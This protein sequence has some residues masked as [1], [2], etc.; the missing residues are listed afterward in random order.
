MA[1]D[2]G[3]TLGGKLL[4]GGV[5]RVHAGNIALLASAFALAGEAREELA[6]RVD[7]LTQERPCI[8]WLRNREARW[9]RP[10][11][12]VRVRHLAGPRL[13]RHATVREIAPSSG[14][15]NGEKARPVG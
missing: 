10:E 14:L 1:L 11:L 15:A 13:V 8:A 12:T 4:D 5:Q 2:V 9:V 6:S 7:A 3:V